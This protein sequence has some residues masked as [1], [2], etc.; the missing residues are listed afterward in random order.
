MF[1]LQHCGGVDGQA[2][3]QSVGT[4]HDWRP[5]F[6]RFFPLSQSEITGLLGL[7]RSRV[8]RGEGVNCDNAIHP[9]RAVRN[10]AAVDVLSVDNLPRD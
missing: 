10:E 1:L 2:A 8:R 7:P 9:K 3:H 6:R 5:R 4:S